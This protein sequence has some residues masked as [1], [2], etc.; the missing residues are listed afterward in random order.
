VKTR[1]RFVT[2]SHRAKARWLFVFFAVAG[3]TTGC[4]ACLHRVPTETVETLPYPTCDGEPMPA[5]EKI[6][7]GHLRSGPGMQDQVVERYEYRRR[8]CYYTLTVRQEWSR[9]VTDAE[10]IFDDAWRPLRAWKRMTVPGTHEVVDVRRYE[11]RTQPATM[12]WRGEEGL[13]RFWFRDGQP[14]A[15]MGPGRGVISAW[16]RA[17][18]GLEVGG[19]VRASLLDFRA[20]VERVGEVALRRDRDRD[21][22]GLGRVH[23]YTVFGRDSVFTDDDGWVVGDLAGMR[24]SSILP[25]PEPAP[26][27]SPSP[28]DPVNTP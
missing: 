5:G 26:L 23:V 16:I 25:G 9:G 6:A 27:P 19:I 10:V 14:T 12:V 18:P 7:E 28:P 20:L 13:Q 11:L 2:K 17:N 4:E 1:P 24:P 8:G 3:S 15:V 22:P 21:V